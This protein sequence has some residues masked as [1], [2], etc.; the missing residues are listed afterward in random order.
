[1]VYLPEQKAEKVKWLKENSRLARASILR[2]TSVAGSGH[3]GGSMSSIDLMLSVYAFANISPDNYL[4]ENRDRVVVSH[5]HIS[6][7]VYTALALFGFH[8][9]DEVVATFRLAGSRFEGHIERHLPGVEWTTGNLGQGLS[10]GCGFALAAR[11]KNLNY[12]VFVLM[13]D[14]EQ[15]KGQVAEARRFARKFRLN[16]LTVIVDYNHMQISGRVEDVMPVNIKENYLSDGWQVIEIDGHDFEQILDALEK[17]TATESPV[18]IL[19]ETVMGKGVS[20]M[21]NNPEYHGRALNREEFQKAMAELGFE[22]DLSKW[23]EMRKSFRYDRPEKHLPHQ[24]PFVVSRG[25]FFIYGAHEKTDNRTAAGKAI[26]DIGRANIK[27]GVPVAVFDCDLASSVKVNYF[28]K[29]FPDYFF[30]AGVSEHNTA[31]TA[32]ALSTQ[33]VLTFLADFGVFGLDEVYN[34]Q[35]LNDINA[36]NLKVLI[37]HCGIDVGEDGRTHHCLDYVGAWRNFFGFKVIVPADPNQTDRAVRYAASTHGNFVIATGRSLT[38]VITDEN[39][40]P[41]FGEDYDFRY[42]EHNVLRKGDHA[43]I[44]C[45]GNTAFRAVAVHDLLKKEG[46]TVEVVNV[47]SPLEISD[48]L[49][50]VV[51]KHSLVVVYE[52]HNINT[53]LYAELSKK[54]VEKNICKRVIVK[55]VSHYAP[56]GRSEDLYAMLGLDPVSVAQEIKKNLEVA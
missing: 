41:F 38:P 49:L 51:R 1:M 44:L 6:P 55:A 53:G 37:T 3:P 52:D 32:G 25:N 43:L 2:M 15:A 23:M 36:T 27:K 39:G 20:F 13:S 54:M 4:D 47:P 48:E 17:A 12:H 46:I 21:E 7:A 8:D 10:A 42:G 34:Q 18:C 9:L 26:L 56:S 14:A 40:R 31:A 33:R 29:E 19:A 45:Y 16:N 22:P 35:R 5:G 24:E 50:E 30:E 11:L 28:A